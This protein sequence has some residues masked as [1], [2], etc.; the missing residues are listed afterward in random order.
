MV[1]LTLQN[2]SPLHLSGIILMKTRQFVSFMICTLENG[3]GIRRY[4]ELIMSIWDMTLTILEKKLNQ[5]SPGGTIIPIISD[6]TQVTLFRN[7]SVYPIYLTIGNIPKEIRCKPSHGMHILLAY[8]PCTQLERITIKASWRQNLANLYHACL[9]HVLAPLKS[10]G[11]QGLRMASGDG[12]LHHCHLLFASFVGDYPEQ[13]LTTG[14]KFG[15]CLKCD[16]DIDK[17]G[18]NTAP[19][20]L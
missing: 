11:L 20:H 4:E 8:L 3:G 6:K 14:I 15:E 16:V 9:S 19:V 10:I 5:H 13:L 17:T 7:K 2:I 18:S 12:T 1:I